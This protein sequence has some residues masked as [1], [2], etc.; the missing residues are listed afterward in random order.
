MNFKTIPEQVI[1]TIC[2]CVQSPGSNNCKGC[3]V[4]FV[5]GVPTPS[6]PTIGDSIW[7]KAPYQDSGLEAIRRMNDSFAAKPSCLWDNVPANSGPMGMS[8]PCPK[9]SP[10]SYAANVEATKVFSSLQSFQS[11]G[12]HRCGNE[13]VLPGYINERGVCD[14]GQCYLPAMINKITVP[15]MGTEAWDDL[16]DQANAINYAST[17]H[18]SQ[19]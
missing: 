6:I 11:D 3:G 15:E 8:C 14:C 12:K 1:C 10:F 4:S 5:F 13:M 18:Q 7:D 2:D 9:C 16:F 19:G 17:S